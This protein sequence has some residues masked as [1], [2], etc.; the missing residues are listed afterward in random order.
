MTFEYFLIA[1]WDM[2]SKKLRKYPKDI[3]RNVKRDI[4]MLKYNPKNGTM[5]DSSK[6]SSLWKKRY[7]EIKEK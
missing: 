7:K 2:I 3:R 1:N 6:S 5:L 4:S